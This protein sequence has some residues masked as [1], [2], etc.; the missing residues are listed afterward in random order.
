MKLNKEK[1][2]ALKV[3]GITHIASVVK[4]HFSTTYY[5]VV[6]IKEIEE[7]GYNWI[8]ASIVQ[9]P[10]GA[11]CRQGVSKVDWSVTEKLQ[12]VR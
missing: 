4:S 10:S 12:N 6:S 8:P 2:E 7:N 3:K 5:N 9:L 1:I 11:V